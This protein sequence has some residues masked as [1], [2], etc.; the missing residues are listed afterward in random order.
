MSTNQRRRG[1][2]GQNGPLQGDFMV[3][4]DLLFTE[5]ERA[6][7]EVSKLTDR[8]INCYLLYSIYRRAIERQLMSWPIF[9]CGSLRAASVLV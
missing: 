7:S 1:A 4:T 2:V 3:Q 6:N 8:R 9:T 5:T